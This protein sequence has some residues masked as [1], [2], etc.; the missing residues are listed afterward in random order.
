MVEQ[1]VHHLNMEG[2]GQVM[3]A[4][5][6]YG[7]YPTKG[8]GYAAAGAQ[9]VPQGVPQGGAA[10]KGYG[11]AAGV[12][13]GQRRKPQGYNPLAILGQGGQANKG[14]GN[15]AYQGAQNGYGTKNG[16]KAING[17]ASRPT[18][19]A[20]S[21]GQAGAKPM[22]GYGRPSYGA[23]TGM[24]AFRGMGVPAQAGHQGSAYGGNGYG[25]KNMGGYR[26]GGFGPS[27][28]SRFGNGGMK[29]PK[30]G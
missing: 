26:P 15:T 14:N 22:K 18:N 4:Q 1:K 17:R 25:A 29:G 23:G 6:G 16:Q 30:P 28:G 24:G 5:N 11:A 20:G 10:M 27:L 12:S 7:G 8:L 19:G 3:G 2:V 9:G 21:T 13:N